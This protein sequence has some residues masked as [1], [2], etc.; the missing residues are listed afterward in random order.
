MEIEYL[1]KPSEMRKARRKIMK[2]LK[3]LG[4]KTSQIDNTG[5]TRMLWDKGTRGSR[6]FLGRMIS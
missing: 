1:C 2:V 6:K 3:D 5:Y 4:I